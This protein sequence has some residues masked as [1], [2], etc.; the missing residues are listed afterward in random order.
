MIIVII[1]PTGV[2]KTKLSIELAKRY[3]AEIINADSMQVYRG[4]DIA[5]A[6]I[7]ET[8]KENIPHHLFDISDV[9]DIYTVYDYQKDCRAKINEILNKNKNVIIVGGTGLYIKAA[10]YDYQFKT[11]YD[12]NDYANLTNEEIFDKI[13]KYDNCC[14]IHINNRKRLVRL[15]NKY[16]NNLMTEKNGNSPLYDFILIG[17]TTD[18]KILYEKI[19]SRVDIMV[20][21]GLIEEAKSL[22]DKH[23]YTKAIQTAIGYKELYPYFDNKYSLEDSL[24]LIK[25][26]S[27]HY[28]K[29]QYTFFNNQFD[30]INWIET[31]YDDFSK[32]ISQAITVIDNK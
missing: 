18:R 6:K 12:L 15:L 10:L 16:E 7:K 23:I 11:E 19:N 9:D 27:R 22:Y 14:D 20:E 17:L 13:K 28:A 3:N 26:N 2:G 32:T 1:G 29:R 8:E 25:K 30:N 21:E 4:L 24:E 31:N 5:T